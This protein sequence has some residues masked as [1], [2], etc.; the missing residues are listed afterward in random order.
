M[1]WP[2]LTHFGHDGSCYLNDCR[3][4]RHRTMMKERVPESLNCREEVI[5]TSRIVG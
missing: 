3:Q 2:N 1:I 5:A 4:T